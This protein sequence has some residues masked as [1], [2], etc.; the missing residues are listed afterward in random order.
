MKI[1]IGTQSAPKVEAIK[2]AIN[3]SP[4]FNGETIEIIDLKVNSEISDMPTSIE[5]NMIG[6]KNRAINSKKEISDA[7]FYIGMEGGTSFFGEK[8][9]LFGVVYILDKN[10]NGHFGF[11]NM[12]EVPQFFHKK[13]YNEK[14]ELGPVLEEATGIQNA[15]KKNGAF[16]AWSDDT[17][18]RKDQFIF[19]FMSAIPVFFNKYYKM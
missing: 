1:V 3:K 2:E 5:E 10:G 12:M 9:Y 17:L 19:A 11:S 18:T 8:T 13:I 16:G 7:D 4:Y 6:A 14:L 15:S